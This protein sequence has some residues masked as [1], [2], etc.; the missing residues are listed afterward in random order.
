MK[1]ILSI[2]LLF[3]FLIGNFGIMIASHY[4]DGKVSQSTLMLVEEEM[5]CIMGEDC[6]MEMSSCPMHQKKQEDPTKQNLKTDNCCENQFTEL[7]VKD[8]FQYEN[9]NI[10]LNADFLFAFV[11]TFSQLNF[12]EHVSPVT[13][14]DISP[15]LPPVDI[16]VR[17]QSFLI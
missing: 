16:I 8:N 14:Y 2:F 7:K 12:N 6:G 15:P 5:D 11:T 17:V 3:V 10:Q 13:Y 4:C 1:K 9:T